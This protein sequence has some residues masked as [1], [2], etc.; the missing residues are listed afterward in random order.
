MIVTAT[1]ESHPRKKPIRT[2]ANAGNPERVIERCREIARF[3]EQPGR[4]TRTFLSPPMR[5][6]HRCLGGW[7]ESLG[8]SVSVDDAGNLHGIHPSN[9]SDPARLIVGSHLDTVPNAGAFDGILGVVLGVALIESLSGRR[10]PFE[11]EIAGFCEEEGVR[12]A[13]P[14]IGS[15]ALAGTIDAA[16]LEKRDANGVTVAQAIR[17]F[18][19]DPARIGEAA[20]CGRHLGYFEFH[21]EQGPVLDRLDLPLGVVQAIAGQ[22]RARLSFRGRANH[23]GTTPMDARHDAVAAAAEWVL[24]VE[25]EAQR[26]P[27]LVA[28]VGTFA[29]L[30]G[31]SNVIAGEVNATLD[32]RHAA[33]AQR[34][35][36]TDRILCAG[37]E[38]AERRG[39][40]FEC[41]G[42]QEQRTV[43]CDS[44]LVAALE[45]AV[46]A[47]GHPLHRMTSGAGHDAMILA[48][49][50][51]MA[52][53]FLR[54]PGG[55][56]HHPDES[57]RPED[58]AAA[59]QAGL[60]FL[61]QLE[62]LNA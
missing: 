18:G 12:F 54:S 62:E 41:A 28:T 20:A 24:A 9:R 34:D 5:D 11:I 42:K 58:V 57:V 53:L 35:V 56:S 32:V 45:R 44:N 61:D 17:E 1:R 8:M 25:R 60:H 21:V 39:L 40:A 50:M 46:V 3:T 10:L 2:M 14:F 27:E 52:M 4:I 13:M 22:T 48:Q 36:A 29:A 31:A 33:D 16:L 47:A 37:R 7:M 59:L 49:K 30:P 55:I 15:R 6:V 19:L 23:A 26:T 51:P 38:I 43:P